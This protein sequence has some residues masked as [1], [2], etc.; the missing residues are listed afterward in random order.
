MGRYTTEWLQQ[1]LRDRL[2]M[3]NHADP[4][5]KRR[6]RLGAKYHIAELRRRKVL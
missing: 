6:N 3:R 4:E 2:A 5:L 1:C